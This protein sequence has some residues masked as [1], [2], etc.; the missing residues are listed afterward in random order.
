MTKDGVEKMK[1]PIDQLIIADAQ[2]LLPH[3]I[4][5]LIE[6][7]QASPEEARIG[8]SKKLVDEIE[9]E[10]RTREEFNDDPFYLLYKR[11]HGLN[12]TKEVLIQLRSLGISDNEMKSE[13]LR[14]YQK[15][16]PPFAII[17]HLERYYTRLLKRRYLQERIVVPVVVSILTTMIVMAIGLIF[18]G[19]ID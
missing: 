18:K 2:V 1:D 12:E 11:G 4:K 14:Y 3:W 16:N 6:N 8:A 10:R 13:L 9:S 7:E 17:P 5:Y 19:C 15:Y